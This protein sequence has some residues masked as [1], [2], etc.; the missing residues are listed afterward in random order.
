VRQR[1]DT[2]KEKMQFLENEIENNKEQEKKISLAER[3]AAKMR[4]E[5]QEAEAQMDQFRS[6]VS[7]VQSEWPLRQIHFSSSSML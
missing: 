2:I 7:N 4:L 6:E 3:A 5:H 1:E